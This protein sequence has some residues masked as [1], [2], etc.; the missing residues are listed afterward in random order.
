MTPEEFKKTYLDTHMELAVTDVLNKGAF[1]NGSLMKME[2]G[3][4]NITKRGKIPGKKMIEA[5]AME[6]RAEGLSHCLMDAIGARVDEL[7][8]IPMDKLVSLGIKTLPQK[9]DQKVDGNFTLVDMV[10][11]TKHA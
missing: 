5:K 1:N 7:L 11:R 10:Q 2:P 9:I 3:D 8:V 6:D 4:K